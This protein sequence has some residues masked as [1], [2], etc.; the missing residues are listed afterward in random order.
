MRTSP[1]A[2]SSRYCVRPQK[3]GASDVAHVPPPLHRVRSLSPGGRGT[4]RGGSI[5][6]Q[7]LNVTILPAPAYFTSG[8]CAAVMEI[9]LGKEHRRK[10]LKKQ[11]VVGVG[12]GYR[13]KKGRKTREKAIIVFVTKKVAPQKLDKEEMAPRYLEGQ[14][15]DVIEIGEV[16]LLESC[17]PLVQNIPVDDRL[18]RR[19]PAPGGVSIGHYR[20]TAGTLGA[21][22]KDLQTGKRLILSNN[23]VLANSSNG[24]D[25]RASIGDP[26]LQ[27]GPY[28]GGSPDGDIIGRLE[29]FAPIRAT[30]QSPSCTTAR[31]WEDLAN[32]FLSAMLP[33]Y[34]VNL[35]RAN[36]E[37]NLVDA[38]LA[39]PLREDDL[40]AELLALG[41]I[42]GVGEVY[43]GDDV[44]FSG[45]TSG[46]VGG[47]VVAR[48]V[49]LYVTMEPGVD[50]YFIDQLVTTAVS[51]PGDSGSLLVD[52]E[53]RAVGLLFAGSET[54]S[55]CNRFVNVSTLLGVE[56][57]TG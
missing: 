23:H 34:R 31:F 35:Q 24:K 51:R 57:V 12:L 2:G 5:A 10:L 43:P 30:F 53:N 20:V 9:K 28:D 44:C 4:G 29:R 27:P 48:D 38:A 45:R 33:H 11:N 54:V 32:R 22:V 39:V 17:T 16:R 36:E 40:S 50:L 55:I 41:R 46:V 14:R 56:P 25:G 21:V 47:S 18:A 37:G 15:V 6:R 19:R 7:R 8:G 52:R 3:Q 49:S 13:K 26:V 1:E 42:S